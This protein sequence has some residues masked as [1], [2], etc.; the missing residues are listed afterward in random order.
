MKAGCMAAWFIRVLEFLA[1]DRLGGPAA[2]ESESYETKV[3]DTLKAIQSVPILKGHSV[4]I[5]WPDRGRAGFKHD[6]LLRTS[7]ITSSD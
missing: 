6:Y 3:D 5:A 4:F 7:P 2:R 1:S